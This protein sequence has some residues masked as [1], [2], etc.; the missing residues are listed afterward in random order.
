MNALNLFN[1]QIAEIT[2]AYSHKVRPA[3]MKKITCSR[4]TFD[5]ILPTWLDTIEHHESFGVMLLNRA[6]KILGVCWIGQGGLSGTVA[7]PKIIFQAALKS[8]AASIIILHNHP[9]KREPR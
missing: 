6:N 9:K 4:D 3:D 2:I 5:F 7:D 1:S 8:N